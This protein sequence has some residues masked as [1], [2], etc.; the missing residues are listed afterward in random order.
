V[1]TCDEEVAQENDQLNLEVKKLEKM[2]SELVKQAKVRPTQDN[3][4]NMVNKLE[5][6]SNFTKQAFQQ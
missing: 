1:E 2:V 3:R 5:N 4:R 6:D